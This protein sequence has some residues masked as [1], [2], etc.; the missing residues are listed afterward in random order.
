MASI[1]AGHGAGVE[2]SVPRNAIL[3]GEKLLHPRIE[4][5]AQ[6]APPVPRGVRERYIETEWVVHRC[7][8]HGAGNGI[9]FVRDRVEPEP[10]RLQRDRAPAGHGIDYRRLA[11]P[12]CTSGR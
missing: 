10:R 11:A 1:R 5:L 6:L 4:A 8:K 7:L 12:Q 2:V 3:R 9:V